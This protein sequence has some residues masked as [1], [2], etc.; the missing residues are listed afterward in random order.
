MNDRSNSPADIIESI[1][2]AAREALPDSLLPDQLAG[3]VKENIRAAIQEVISGLDVV[4][5]EEFD[6]QTE[7]LKKT[8][9]KLDEMESLIADLEEQL[10]K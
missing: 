9:S 8:R 3:D 5:R 2:Q 6:V 4:T 1:M 10:G 7:V